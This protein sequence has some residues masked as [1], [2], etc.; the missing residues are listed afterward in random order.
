MHTRTN[1]SE[2]ECSEYM[3]A[4][5]CEPVCVGMLRVATVSC[6]WRHMYL[7]VRE[8][9]FV[10]CAAKVG[11]VVVAVTV[12]AATTIKHKQLVWC[13]KYK[14]ENKLARTRAHAHALA[15]TCTCI[16]TQ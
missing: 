10:L 5:A 8:K 14:G 13:K 3:C 4:S 15:H 6:V 11:A 12:G 2:R 7:I 1:A 9:N 16:C